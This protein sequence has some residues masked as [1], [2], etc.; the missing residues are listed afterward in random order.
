MSTVYT[1]YS[2]NGWQRGSDFSSWGGSR[3][4]SGTGTATSDDDY[5][6]YNVYLFDWVNFFK[7]ILILGPSKK[8]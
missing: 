1:T 2:Q 8:I 7:I 5:Y 6:V 4:G 3:T